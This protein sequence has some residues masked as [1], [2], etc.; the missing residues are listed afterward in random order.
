MHLLQAEGEV[1][2]KECA[3]CWAVALAFP[4]STLPVASCLTT[5]LSAETVET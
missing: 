2:P 3:W 5:L 1:N 4:S